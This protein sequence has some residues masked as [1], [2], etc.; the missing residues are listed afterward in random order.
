V[1]VAVAA[2]ETERLLLEPFGEED[3]RA[4]VD[5]APG[6]RRW[7][8]GYPTEGDVEIARLV[9]RDPPR[10]DLAVA[11]G[12]RQIVRR[13]DRLVVG[14][15]GFFGPP[16][17]GGAVIVG[18][19]VAEEHRCQGVATEAL[20]AAVRF[21]FAH[22][23]VRRVVADTEAGNIASQRVLEK[24]GLRRAGERGRLLVYEVRRHDCRA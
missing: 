13:D 12:P 24:A 10:D 16:D 22:P 2:I 7:A 6:G 17:A 3:A 19:G 11:F 21:A 8:V 4:V 23:A 1:T 14:G 15:I 9:L 20:R 5:R 18:Y